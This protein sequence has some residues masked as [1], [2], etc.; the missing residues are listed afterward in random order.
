MD[1]S[2]EL[3]RDRFSKAIDLLT[4]AEP[5]IESLR[6]ARLYYEEGKE[7]L[8]AAVADRAPSKELTELSQL[9][10][11]VYAVLTYMTHLSRPY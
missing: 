11:R 8:L 7:S 3:A 9:E 1:D 2:F 5:T 4:A 6:V 10:R